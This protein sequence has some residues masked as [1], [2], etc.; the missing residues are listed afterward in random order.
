MKVPWGVLGYA[1]IARES[2]IPAILRSRN[3]ELYAVA[4][5]TMESRDACARAFGCPRL[6][7]D[8]EELLADP[9]VKAVYIP[10]PNSMH[11]EWTV[12]A[13]R[14]GKHVLCEKPLAL[15]HAEAKLMAD[16]CA[17][18]GV[19]LMEAFM[20]RYTDRIRKTRDVLESGELGDVKVVDSCYRF[21]LTREG[22]IKMQA[23]LGG[24]ALFDVGCYPVSFI[25]MVAADDPVSV[26]A[27]A[28]FQDGV[29]V[30]FSAVL[31]FGRGI[32]A[33]ASCGFNAFG[34]IH[35]HIVGTRGVLEIPA[36]F[37]GTGGN[38]TLAAA[39]GTREIAVSESDR[40]LLEIEDFSGA[41]LEERRPALGMDESLR[42]V[43]ILEMLHA[44]CRPPES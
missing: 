5:H 23:A 26:K 22:T 35:S 25:S 18:A 38:I 31:S 13:A 9:G 37:Q 27:E 29:D 17:R 10:L 7:A 43:R 39:G 40:Y 30:L 16:E 3:A 34:R 12:K 28:V 32:I 24:G 4:S 41:V 8:Y 2:V 11:C 15:S 14:A 33:H 19:I 1:R 6:Y 20:Y 36:T 21:R 44:A 42:S